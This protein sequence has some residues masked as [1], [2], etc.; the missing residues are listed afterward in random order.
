MVTV[1][2]GY[3]LAFGTVMSGIAL[4]YTPAELYARIEL[5]VLIEMDCFV[6][7]KLFSVPG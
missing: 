4:Q 2:N 5:F 6:R 1:R 7:N 3:R